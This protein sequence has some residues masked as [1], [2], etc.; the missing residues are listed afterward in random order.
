MKIMCA[1]CFNQK[2]TL[3]NSCSCTSVDC[4]HNVHKYMGFHKVF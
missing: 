3:G 1:T 4:V 2:K